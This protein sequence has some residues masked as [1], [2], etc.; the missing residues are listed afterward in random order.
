M[1]TY[2]LTTHSHFDMYKTAKI[3]IQ[4]YVQLSNE[5]TKKKKLTFCVPYFYSCNLFPRKI[6]VFK[7]MLM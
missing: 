2:P 7:Q 6:Q 4:N 5:T 1:E 3:I